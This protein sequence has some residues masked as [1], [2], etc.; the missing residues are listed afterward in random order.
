MEARR[1]AQGQQLFD[2]LAT[3]KSEEMA[4]T[5]ALEHALGEH[6]HATREAVE[7]GYRANKTR[8]DEL[9]AEMLSLEER[10]T[11][12]V[13]D[14]RMKEAGRAEA[15][16]HK[17]QEQVNEGVSSPCLSNITY[18]IPCISVASGATD[19]GHCSMMRVVRERLPAGL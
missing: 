2:K 7:T 10:L 4:R 15:L 16:L 14:A 1:Q 13:E 19:V 18:R 8:S 6:R 12:M 11:T 5:D 3:T 17:T 9:H